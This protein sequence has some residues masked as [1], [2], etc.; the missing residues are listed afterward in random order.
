LLLANAAT[1]GIAR[2][3]PPSQA[4][5][6]RGGKNKN[7]QAKNIRVQTGAAVILFHL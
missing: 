7:L 5:N 2:T 3:Q 1:K 6:T 4:S